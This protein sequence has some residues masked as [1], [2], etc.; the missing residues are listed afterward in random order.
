MAYREPDEDSLEREAL[1]A[2]DDAAS[3]VGAE[4]EIDAPVVPLGPKKRGRKPGSPKVPGSGRIKG[5][6][7][8]AQ[9]QAELR[10]KLWT[11]ADEVFDFHLSI[12]R[13]EPQRV[14]G[15]TGKVI[16][17]RPTLQQRMESA[18]YL[19]HKMVPDLKSAEIASMNLNASLPI[20]TEDEAELRKALADY[21]AGQFG[22]AAPV[23]DA[24][25]P[26]LSAPHEA[27]NEDRWGGFATQARE[28]VGNLDSYGSF[29]D[30][31]S[32]N[33][34]TP[35]SDT[36]DSKI[37]SITDAAQIRRWDSERAALSKPN[38]SANSRTFPNGFRWVKRYDA[39]IS[40]HVYDLFDAGGSH[41]GV[42]RDEARAS[43]WCEN[44]GSIL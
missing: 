28:G 13:G 41:C 21:C 29:P 32:Q 24:E 36:P 23:V 20:S 8:K 44:E 31:P 35:D 22:V 12:L 2:L 27:A 18:S 6:P 15:P 37:I 40:K 10:G 38:G 33:I 34:D 3:A 16:W 7:T 19:G 17:S 11:Y 4:P 30:T 14:S 9:T 42:R 5:K 26:K 43:Q 1:G 25:L 39:A